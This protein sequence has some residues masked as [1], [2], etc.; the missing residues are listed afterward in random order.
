MDNVLQLFKDALVISA[1][2]YKHN[3]QLWYK[4]NAYYLEVKEDTSRIV[5]STIFPHHFQCL[6]SGLN[7][8]KKGNLLFGN[9]H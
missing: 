3:E 2:I 9:I 7:S 6:Y 5:T 4:W 1:P 8:S